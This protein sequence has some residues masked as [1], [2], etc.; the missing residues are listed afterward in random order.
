MNLKLLTGGGLALALILLLAVNIFSSAAFRTARLDLTDNQRYTLSDGTRKILADLPEPVTL[1]LF[2]SQQLATRLPGLS[3]YATRVRELLEEYQRAANGNIVLTVIDP[4][5]FSE[6]EDRAVAYGLTG[7][8]LDDGESTFYF[9]LVVTGPAQ[10]EEVIPFLSQDREPTLEYDVTKL[11]YQV[12]HPKRTTVALLTSLPMDGLPPM[13]SPVQNLPQPWTVLEQMRQFFEVRELD[14]NIAV[15]PDDVAV[16]M[17]V[18]PKALSDQA[19]YAIDQFVLRGGRVLAF[20]D[21]YAEADSAGDMPDRE[22]TSPAL[23][24]LLQ[25][26]GVRLVDGK[27]VGDS[28]LAQKVR[29]NLGSRIV[30]A[31][32]PVWMELTPAQLN[33]DDIITTD[34]GNLLLATPGRLLPAE[35]A[36]TQVTPLLFTTTAAAE[37][38]AS[39]LGGLND[40]R[41]LLRNFRPAGERFTLAARVTGKINSAFPDGPPAGEEAPRPPHLA[42]SADAINLIVV[43]DSDL[44]QDRFWVQ[45]QNLLGT[46]IAIPT[47]A[48]GSFVINAL[49][50]LAGSN[51]LIS[52]RNRG[53][54]SRPFTRV[55]AIRQ[56]AE[57][58]YREKEQQLLDRLQDTERKLVELERGKQDGNAAI[59]SD[60]QRQ[61]L[62]RF[63]QEKI[64]LRQ[65]LRQVRH[66]LRNNIDR[67]EAWTK[68]VNIGLIPLLIALGGVAVAIHRRRRRQL[69]SSTTATTG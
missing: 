27:V 44:L 69:G 33:G 4:E 10:E 34:L 12:A 29:F 48:N 13:V 46:R 51:D 53:S 2:L 41:E 16:L 24:R 61:E 37:I 9:G 5:P 60:E 11:I 49:D 18:H 56:D 52:V 65:D 26:W 50:N 17:L 15:I 25:S 40:P 32:Y 59:L 7:I 3:S 39:R 21:P 62:E 31:D 35:P 30:T 64:Q 54:S 23:T 43:A 67:L 22:G 68:F 42:A 14:E 20:V 36:G 8:P 47:A 45:T 28:Q 57:Q 1:K 19:L 63:R 58:Q 66:E 55:A 38:D 6:A